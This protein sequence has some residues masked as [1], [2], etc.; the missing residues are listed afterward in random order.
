MKDTMFIGIDLGGTNIKAGL[1]DGKGVI[2]AEKE[3]AT[4]VHGGVEHVMARMKSLILDLS[5]Q[6]DAVIGGVGVGL[7]GMVDVEKGVYHEGPNLPGWKNEPL[8]EKLGAMVE[9]PIILDN[10]ANVAALGEYAYG[11]G[12]GVRNMLMV[13]L[14]TGVGGG[15]IL[16]G[17]LFYGA[18]YSAGEF[19]HTIINFEG[20]TC[21]CGRPGC[22]EAYIGT[23]GILRRVREKLQ[24][25]Q[26]S[27]LAQIEPSKLMPKDISDA[28]RLGDDVA[29]EVLSD[30]GR[31]LGIATG[32][33]ANLLNIERV[34]VGGGVANA[35]DWILQPARATL[36][37][38][39]LKVPSETVD[40]VPA[41]LG[42][43]AGLV[44]A[45]HLAMLAQK[46]KS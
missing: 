37:E 5:G 28:A 30:T 46:N 20:P 22:V 3:I 15:L 44:G 6:A 41:L 26:A 33:V 16:N 21:A 36:K 17:K 34:V 19:G 31:Y 27:S 2:R 7:P 14:G 45:A 13:T 35:G 32:N 10:D 43:H 18:R 39:A 1:V 38:I 24:A 25:G 4:E 9:L 42:N 8:V 23:Q 29:T 11:A 12:R 40:M